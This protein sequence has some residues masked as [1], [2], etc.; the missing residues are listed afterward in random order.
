MESPDM[1]RV[2][3]DAMLENIGDLYNVSKGNL[4]DEQV[5]RVAVTDALVDT[6]AT[7]LSV[8]ISLIHQLGLARVSSKRIPSSAGPVETGMYEASRFPMDYRC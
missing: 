6:G 1:G 3:T 5:H 2:L 7:L 8:P 4:P